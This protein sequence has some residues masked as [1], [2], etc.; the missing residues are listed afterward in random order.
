MP[1]NI[2]GTFT[3]ALQGNP[4]HRLRWC[5]L[6]EEK[7]LAEIDTM[8][9]NSFQVPPNLNISAGTGFK[10]FNALIKALKGIVGELRKFDNFPNCR[11]HLSTY[12]KQEHDHAGQRERWKAMCGLGG[13]SWSTV[14]DQTHQ[15]NLSEGSLQ[16][17]YLHPQQAHVGCKGRPLVGPVA[18][19]RANLD[20]QT[21]G[22]ASATTTNFDGLHVCAR[23]E[24]RFVKTML[25]SLRATSILQ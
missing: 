11:N 25:G 23:G 8:M 7:Y 4:E 12:Q 14:H 18:A 2:I 1:A 10:F 6:Q 22:R 24:R 20:L 19:P 13:R 15:N 9:K 17:Y 16:C 5:H 3:Q 21:W